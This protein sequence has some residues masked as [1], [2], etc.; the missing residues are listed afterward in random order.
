MPHAAFFLGA[1][2]GRGRGGGAI[3]VVK[4]P[5]PKALKPLFHATGMGTTGLLEDCWITVFRG[6]SRRWPAL[7][8]RCVSRWR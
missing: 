5:A 4:V 3:P 7:R 2:S 1:R 8:Y 6:D